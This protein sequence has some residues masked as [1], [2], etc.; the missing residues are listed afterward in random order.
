MSKNSLTS[1]TRK[2]SSSYQDLSCSIDHNESIHVEKVGPIVDSPNRSFC[3]T[4]T[5]AQ[6]R[7]SAS[8]RKP[9]SN[10]SKI[11]RLPAASTKSRPTSSRASGDKPSL[12]S[13]GYP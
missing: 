11:P 5:P 1:L 6:S 7:D 4:S 10:S 9:K 12:S 2:S 3:F 8:N 13:L